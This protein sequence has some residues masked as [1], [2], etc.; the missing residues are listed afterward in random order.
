MARS[1]NADPIAACPRSCYTPP[2]MSDEKRGNS[3]S[4][5]SLFE[6]Q[7]R[8]GAAPRRRQPRVGD[9]LEVT[10]AKVGKD[11]VFVDLDGKHQAYIDAAELRAPDGTL[12]VKVGDTL[13]T[14]V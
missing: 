11:A 8:G 2:P 10:V 7:P 13:S 6:Q 9:K 1:R 4:F 14:F 3:E 5:A 12:P